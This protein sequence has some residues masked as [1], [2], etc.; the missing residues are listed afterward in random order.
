MKSKTITFK[1]VRDCHY[2][3]REQNH[4]FIDNGIHFFDIPHVDLTKWNHAR[5]EITIKDDKEDP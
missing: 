3:E 5:V 2:V 4:R 1:L